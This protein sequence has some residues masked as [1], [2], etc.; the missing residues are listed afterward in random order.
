MKKHCDNCSAELAKFSMFSPAKKIYR[1]NN[2][3]LCLDCFRKI[4]AR[5]QLEA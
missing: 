5:E 3:I 1:F 2:A 4:S